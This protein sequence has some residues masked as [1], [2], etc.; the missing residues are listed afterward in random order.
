MPMNLIHVTLEGKNMWKTFLE[1]LDIF[2]VKPK[3]T[4]PIATKYTL[5]KRTCLLLLREVKYRVPEL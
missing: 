2:L 4:L 5:L 1:T 3:L